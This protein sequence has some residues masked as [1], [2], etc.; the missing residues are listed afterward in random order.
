[1]VLESGLAEIRDEIRPR[2]VGHHQLAD[3]VV[4]DLATGHQARLAKFDRTILG[5]VPPDSV[6]RDVVALIPA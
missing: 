1:M 5:L 6:L 4:L 2:I 3:A